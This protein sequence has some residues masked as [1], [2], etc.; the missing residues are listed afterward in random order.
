MFYLGRNRDKQEK[1]LFKYYKLFNEKKILR[2]YWF[3]VSLLI[4]SITTLILN[5]CY[6]L[7]LRCYYVVSHQ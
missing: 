5:K 3:E 7:F 6:F 2:A 1:C 4:I